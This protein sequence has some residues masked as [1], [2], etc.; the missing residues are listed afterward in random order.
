MTVKVAVLDSNLWPMPFKQAAV[1]SKANSSV[2]KSS[3]GTRTHWRSYSGII[4]SLVLFLSFSLHS[5]SPF[6][7]HLGSSQSDLR[8]LKKKVHWARRSEK[9]KGVRGFLTGH[10]V[11]VTQY[12]PALSLLIFTQHQSSDGRGES[13]IPALL[14]S[15]LDVTFKVIGLN[16]RDG[17]TS[18][19]HS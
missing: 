1:W 10:I 4:I 6:G 18:F 11:N 16:M 12:C 19:F 13:G 14:M 9:V 7:T 3:Q 17:S 2:T 5:L 15:S 8:S